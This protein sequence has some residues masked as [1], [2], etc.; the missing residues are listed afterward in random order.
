V[1]CKTCH[2]PLANLAENRCPECGREFDPNDPSTVD[3]STMRPGTR[4][5]IRI[6]I[7]AVLLIGLLTGVVAIYVY[8]SFSSAFSNFHP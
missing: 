6:A 8:W 5:A 2:Y 1:R 3:L 4:V 7:A